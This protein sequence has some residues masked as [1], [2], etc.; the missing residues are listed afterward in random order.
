MVDA[1]H[2]FSHPNEMMLTVKDALVPDVSISSNI[3]TETRTFP[4]S[5][6]TR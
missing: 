3:G 2:E 4:S 6:C 1:Y 5:F